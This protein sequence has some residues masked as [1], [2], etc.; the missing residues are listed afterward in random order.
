MNLVTFGKLSKKHQLWKKKRREPAI[1]GENPSSVSLQPHDTSDSHFCSYLS[2]F[3]VFGCA[4]TEEFAALWNLVGFRDRCSNSC[5]GQG[6]R[7]RLEEQPI[8]G[9]E[10]QGDLCS[11]LG[12]MM[13]KMCN[14]IGASLSRPNFVY[15]F[16]Y[17]F[18]YRRRVSILHTDLRLGRC[19]V[20]CCHGSR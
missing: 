16:I 12:G 17:N 18:A 2:V 11:E 9:R 20:P 8:R 3:F 10:G 7:Q 13:C 4:V 5:T 6:S 15:R 14:I 1:P 19:S